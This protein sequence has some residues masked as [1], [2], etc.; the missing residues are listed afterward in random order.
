[1]LGAQACAMVDSD[2]RSISPEWVRDLLRPVT[3]E[4]YDYVTPLYNRYKYDGTIT[5]NIVYV[6][7]RALYGKRVRQPIGGDF[8]FSPKLVSFCAEQDVWQTDVARFGIDIWLTTTAIVR[9]FKI[10]QVRLGAKV[11]DVKDPAAQLGPMFQQV[12]ATMMKL[13][14]ENAVY[15][16]KIQGSKKVPTL[17]KA[18]PNQPE[19]FEVDHSAL[20]HRFKLGYQ[21]FRSV[22]KGFLA[23]DTYKEL[24]SVARLSVKNFCFSDDLWCRVLSDYAVTFH[25]W[26]ANRRVLTMLMVPLYYGRIASFINETKDMS[27]KE[28]EQVIERT[29][30]TF[31]RNKPYLVKRWRTMSDEL[32]WREPEKIDT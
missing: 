29:A 32:A 6:L 12:V 18:H 28:A 21:Q 1:M 4:G 19:G 8:A 24:Q 17:G 2:L 20:V 30:E 11:H 10:C 22:W 31:E 3:E 14:D 13:M 25:S 27:N 15:W 26:E 7:T 16:M 23:E 9:G 5:N